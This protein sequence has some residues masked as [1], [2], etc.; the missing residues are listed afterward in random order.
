MQIPDLSDVREETVK[1]G[2]LIKNL[3][4]I[5]MTWEMHIAKVVD[6][7]LKKVSI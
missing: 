1:D 3:E 4:D 6:D 7:C 5:L 2:E